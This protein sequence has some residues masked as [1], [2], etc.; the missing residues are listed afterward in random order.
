[1]DTMCAATSCDAL[2]AAN[3]MITEGVYR[4]APTG[5]PSQPTYCR[6]SP[7]SSAMGG[8]TL[9]MRSVYTYD[10]QTSLLATDYNNFYSTPVGNPSPGGVFRMPGRYWPTFSVRGGGRQEHLFVLTPRTDMGADCSAL[11]FKF[12]DGRWT[13]TASGPGTISNIPGSGGRFFNSNPNG[14][15]HTT[16]DDMTMSRCVTDPM[17]RSVPWTYN[18]C[19]GFSPARQFGTQNGGVPRPFLV[20]LEMGTDIRGTSLTTACGSATPLRT[21]DN[22]EILTSVEYYIR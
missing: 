15:F 2:F 18:N 1:M 17:L 19:G 7:H 6:F 8:W 4:I 21:T 3:S 11:F 10:G 20:D 14:R 16:S 12:D 22:Y 13:F 9:V 5:L